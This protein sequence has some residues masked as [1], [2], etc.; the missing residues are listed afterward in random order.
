MLK[1]A[2]SAALRDFCSR[3][4]FGTKILGYSLA[5]PPDASSAQFW[6]Q[7]ID[8]EMTA[9]VAL[10]YGTA[11]ISASSSADFEE[12]R[13]FIRMI[14]FCTLSLDESVCVKLGLDPSRT[15]NIVRFVSPSKSLRGMARLPRY[16]D[17][18]EVFDLLVRSGF[19]CL[20]EKNEWIADV[21]RRMNRGV[22]QWSI[23]EQDGCVAACACALFVTDS[24]A[25]L[26]CVAAD[27]KLRTRGLGSEAVLTVA[28]KYKGE[29]K[30]VELFCKDDSIVE[31]YKKS[32]FTPVG[33]WA[34]YDNE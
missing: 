30:R 34:E 5:C 12:L 6:L 33:R 10:V 15:G 16:P 29:G 18:R 11:V 9:A 2:D 21:S 20:G 1:T 19:D 32:G 26:G 28:D 14:G 7:E 13:E 27:E 25:F 3:D 22:S 8:G 4:A 23:I 31:F 17:L 24:A